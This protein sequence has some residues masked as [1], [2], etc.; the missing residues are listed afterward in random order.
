MAKKYSLS[1]RE[2]TFA[3]DIVNGYWLLD[4]YRR[5]WT[6][7]YNDTKAM[8]MARKLL[9]K[10]SIS[11]RIQQLILERQ[12][13]VNVDEAFVLEHLKKIVLERSGTNQ[14]VRALELL[15]KYMAMWVDKQ[16]I[17]DTRGQ[18]EIAEQMWERRQAMERGEEVKPLEE[19]KESS[20]ELLDFEIK[21]GTDG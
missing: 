10:E 5:G 8:F 16:V 1:D 15:G 18:R 3:E 14:A 19:V 9:K 2:A 17:D 13:N 6:N 20:V 12:G 7:S 11:K 21:D 4:A